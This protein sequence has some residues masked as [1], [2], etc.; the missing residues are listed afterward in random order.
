[1]GSVIILLETK[2]HLC[3]KPQCR[4]IGV[5]IASFCISGG[6]I[7]FLPWLFC[8]PCGYILFNFLD[9][10]ALDMYGCGEIWAIKLANPT[11]GKQWT[12]FFLWE[13]IRI[14]SG[15]LVDWT[16]CIRFEMLSVL[17]RLWRWMGLTSMKIG[18][19]RLR[20]WQVLRVRKQVRE[21]AE[22]RLKNRSL[23]ADSIIM[24][25]INDAAAHDR[26][27]LILGTDA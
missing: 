20:N 21:R 12:N 22:I 4:Y 8:P 18:D 9:I 5:T 27:T 24:G 11:L 2:N 23:F 3:A 10:L 6:L 14:H 13:I 16:H 26:M 25:I 1:M 15:W 7:C 19:S 17:F